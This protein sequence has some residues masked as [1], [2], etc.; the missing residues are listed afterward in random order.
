[1]AIK[2]GTSDISKVYLGTTE[3]DKIYL[4]A[5]E[6]Y[7]AVDYGIYVNEM[8]ARAT[9]LS[10]TLPSDTTLLDLQ[11]RLVNIGDTA[12]NKL[13]VLHIYSPDAGTLDFFTLNV[14]SPTTY[15]AT[16]VNSPTSSKL[17]ILTNGSSSYIDS[18]YNPSLGLNYTLN[19]ASINIMISQNSSGAN[20]YLGGGIS[21]NGGRTDIN[22]FGN[23]NRDYSNVND[24][25]NNLTGVNIT[26]G[27]KSS[28]RTSS[29]LSTNYTDG[30]A[31]G[32]HTTTS[33]NMPD[34][35]MFLGAFNNNGSVFFHSTQR[36]VS[37]FLG[38][39]LTT[40][41]MATISTQITAFYGR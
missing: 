12:L 33:T 29:T 19:D 32:S 39:S 31:T 21:T 23:I 1:M 26:A 11:T 14:V 27:L 13:D 2:L 41:E 37:S 15:Q 6:I 10:Y 28:V 18:N 17:G 24:G 40:T 16:L 8:I 34:L 25:F 35:N 38:A 5:T 7:T 3:V 4:G 22:L 20:S 9:A 30:V 36:I